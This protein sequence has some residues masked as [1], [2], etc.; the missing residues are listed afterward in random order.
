LDGV[1]FKTVRLANKVT[2][3]AD[4]TFTGLDASTT[5]TVKAF[6]DNISGMSSGLTLTKSVKTDAKAIEIDTW[7][8]YGSNGSASASATAA[9]AEAIVYGGSTKDF[10]YLVWNDMVDKV[11]EV[12]DATGGKWDS[13]YA[14]YSGTRMKS[15]D[16]TLTATRFNS[17]RLNIQN[18]VWL[19]PTSV[20]FAYTGDEVKGSYFTDMMSAVN[21]WINSVTD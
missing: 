18:N 19:N 7:Y 17:L 9:A 3:G 20:P 14:S 21:R 13:T 16:K 2:S 11:K 5:Y 1:L 15:S 8:W 12:L 4:Y 10:S 6:V